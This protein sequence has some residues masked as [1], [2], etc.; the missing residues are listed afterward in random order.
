MLADHLN[1][2]QG[3]KQDQYFSFIF[4]ALLADHLNPLQGLKLGSS[5]VDPKEITLADHLN[6][7]QGLKPVSVLRMSRSFSSPII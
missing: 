1:P 2:L 7:L 3:L 5:S 6:P 4:E